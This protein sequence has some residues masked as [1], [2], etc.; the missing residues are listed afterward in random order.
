MTPTMQP[1]RELRDEI[2][3]GQGED[4]IVVTCRQLN[5]EKIHDVLRDVRVADIVELSGWQFQI[6]CDPY[7]TNIQQLQIRP[8][9]SSWSLQHD[10]FEYLLQIHIWTIVCNTV[11]KNQQTNGKCV[12]F[13]GHETS[14]KFDNDAVLH[15]CMQTFNRTFPNHQPVCIATPNEGNGKWAVVRPNRHFAERD[16]MLREHCQQNQT[17]C[18]TFN[19]WATDCAFSR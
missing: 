14:I 6:M 10:E 17:Q 8:R 4:C 9:L 3:F 19:S 15:A 11:V 1:V 18:P 13:L 7:E 2:T 5:P 16:S 12:D